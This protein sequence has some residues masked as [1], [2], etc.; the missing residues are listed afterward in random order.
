MSLTVLKRKAGT[1]YGKISSQ[2]NKNG[3]GNVGFSINNPRRV[4]SHS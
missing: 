4:D 3:L 1:K 2:K